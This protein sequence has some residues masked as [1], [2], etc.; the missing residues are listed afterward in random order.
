MIHSTHQ[1]INPAQEPPPPAQEH[2]QH[3][4]D[5]LAWLKQG[6]QQILNALQAGSTQQPA[7][8]PQNEA[9][10][11]QMGPST[12]NHAGAE[13]RDQGHPERQEARKSV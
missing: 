5:L 11:T 7:A 13:P 3:H 12:T 4:N 9:P 10:H 6:E 1:P 2:N 8:Q